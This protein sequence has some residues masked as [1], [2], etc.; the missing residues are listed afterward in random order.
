V[1]VVTGATGGIGSATSQ[2]LSGDGYVIVAQYCTNSAKAEQLASAIA[3]QGGR[4]V[5]V[6]ADLS[7]VEGVAQLVSSVRSLLYQDPSLELWGLVNNAAKLLGPGFDGATPEQFDEYFAVNLRAPFFLAQHLT[8]VM[9]RGGSVVN[10]SSASAHFSS[11]GDIIY[12]MT[13]AGL[14]SFT[15]N[16]AEAVA[17]L[18]LRVNTVVPGFTDN[19]HPAF[20]HAAV[21][22]Y[23]SSFAVLGDVSMPRTVAEA[24]RFLISERASRTTGAL[25]DVSGGSTLGARGGRAAS[26]GTLI[27]DMDTDSVQGRARTCDPSNRPPAVDEAHVP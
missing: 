25:L 13:K 27:D 4:C 12:A 22:Q 2:L 6:A 11:P 20:R 24:V 5:A 17:P 15:R 16:L 8:M 19:G 26:V 14:E 23:M 1:V 3:E 7:D 21:R 9:E 10:V 18:G